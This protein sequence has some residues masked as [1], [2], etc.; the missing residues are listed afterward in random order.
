MKNEQERLADDKVIA[1]RLRLSNPELWDSLTDDQRE[2]MVKEYLEVSSIE[3]VGIARVLEEHRGFR[4]ALILTLL[5]AL[6]GV[7]GG[8]A[9]G[10]VVTLSPSFLSSLLIALICLAFFF[11]AMF[12]LVRNIEGVSAEW[13]RQDRVLPYLVKEMALRE[14]GEAEKDLGQDES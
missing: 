4:M 3:R 5:G 11:V 14:Q 8:L 1:K 10:A 12:W 2:W 6:L 7:L 9:G 13:L